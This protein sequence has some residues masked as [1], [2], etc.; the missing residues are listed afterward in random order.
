VDMCSHRQI[1]PIY[2]PWLA[3]SEGAGRIDR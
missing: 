3:A 2:T 1:A